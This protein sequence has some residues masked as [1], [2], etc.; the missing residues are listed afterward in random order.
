MKSTQISIPGNFTFEQWVKDMFNTLN[1]YNVPIPS[2]D[3]SK[4]RDWFYAFLS[5]NPSVSATLPTKLLFPTDDDW[6][7]WA[8]FFMTDINNTR[9]A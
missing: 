6:R 7:R 3:P 1:Q 5:L 8:Y 9:S 2:K 4:W